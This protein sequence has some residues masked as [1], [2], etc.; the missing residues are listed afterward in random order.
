MQ[1]EVRTMINETQKS[2]VFPGVTEEKSFAHPPKNDYD[3]LETIQELILSFYNPELVKNPH[4]DRKYKLKNQIENSS[5]PMQLSVKNK[6]FGET[7]VFKY[8]SK[9]EL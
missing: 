8:L 9:M 5:L 2:Q 7:W 3:D 6:R 4:Q 1:S